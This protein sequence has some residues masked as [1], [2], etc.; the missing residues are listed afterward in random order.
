M[1][2]RQRRQQRLEARLS[3]LLQRTERLEKRVEELENE[4]AVLRAANRRLRRD[5]RKLKRENRRLAEENR[6]LRREV[7]RLGGN[8]EAVEN[9][10]AA[11]LA[12]DED[13]G[14]AEPSDQELAGSGHSARP[15]SNAA[16]RRRKRGGQVFHKGT[17]AKLVPPEK[18]D[19][20][21][22]LKPERC[23][24]CGET[25]TEVDPCPSRHQV[26][27][28][29]E[30]RVEVTE[31][32]QHSVLCGCG[33]LNRP[34]LPPGVPRGHLAFGPRLQALVALLTGGCRLSK[35]KVKGLF[36]DLFGLDISLG[37]VSNCERAVSEALATPVEEAHAFAQQQ[38]AANVDETGWVEGKV[39]AYLWSMVTTFVTI[40]LIRGTRCRDTAQELLGS[41][42]GTLITDRLRTYY[43][44][45]IYRHQFC[46]AHLKRR[47]EEFLLAGPEAKRIGERLLKEH[48]QMYAWWYRVR[49]GTL[50]RSTFRSYMS[51]L[52][53]R[54]RAL[55]EEGAVCTDPETAGTCRELL[56]KFE[57]LWTFVRVEGVEPTNN[58][59]E[60]SL[61]HGV[62][63]RKG[64]FGTDSRQ[65][66]VFVER[67]LTVVASLGQQKR[68]VF[69]FLAE[70][71]E[72]RVHGEE[73]PSLLPPEELVEGLSAA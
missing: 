44:W 48:R 14:D 24:E 11:S 3:E 1:S 13:A 17:T 33:K 39:K 2:R 42:N 7:R 45:P 43:Y 62:L 36:L 73:P 21:V 8:V 19:R 58:A 4:N 40:F 6:L 29:P 64:S 70:A 22:H 15:G 37:S 57:A 26:L 66:S 46:W 68:N 25:L 18:V 55:L 71:C 53:R 9:E 59:A 56:D 12:E 32:Q 16:G 34:E 38:R 63:W 31:W 23:S 50:R 27:E 54:V 35:R 28:T 72:A 69:A 20:V 49:D 41:F 52:R 10:A 65:G 5:N 30:P 60:R 47:F 67:V 51:P 61:R